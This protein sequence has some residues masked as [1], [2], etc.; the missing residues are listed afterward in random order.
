[1]TP[2]PPFQL[3][4]SLRYDPLLLTS[5]ENS[6]PKLNFLAPSPFYM[7]A[8]HRDRMVEAAQHFDFDDV[9]KRLEDGV[10]LH[11]ELLEEVEKSGEKGPLKVSLAEEQDGNVKKKLIHSY[12]AAYIV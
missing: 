5:S 1:M 6:L 3:F 2:S 11:R 4:T 9:V 8:Y 10:K 12:Q 7:L